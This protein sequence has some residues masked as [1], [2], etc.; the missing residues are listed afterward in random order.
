MSMLKRT[1]VK[2]SVSWHTR[3]SWI[4]GLALFLFAFSGIMHPLMIWT[5]PKP[6]SFFPPQVSLSAEL[7]SRIPVT[8]ENAGI[9]QAVIVRMVPAESGVLLQITEHPEMPRR[10]FDLNNSV[11]L[12]DYDEK[13]AIWLAR[14][15]TGLNNE[16]VAEVSFLNTFSDAYPW[17]NRLLPIYKITFDT[18]DNRTAFI[19]TELGV[20]GNLTNDWKIAIQGVFQFIH[21]W[22]WLDDLEHT[23]V[24]LM[25]CLLLSLLGMSVTGIAMILLLKNREM[26]KKR[27]AHR[28]VAYVIWLPLLMFSTSG[29]YH[30]LQYAYG[31]NHRGLQLSKPIAVTKER[32]GDNMKWL[33][34]YKN[35]ELNGLSIVEGPSG[36][37]LY[38]LSIPQGK[39]G[40][41]LGRQ[42][43]FDGVPI[44]KPALYFNAATGEESDIS[45][46]DMA[47]YYAGEQLAYNESNIVNTQ[48]VTHFGPDYDFRNK[49]LPV[50][51]ID[52][53]AEA[54]DMVFIDPANGMLVDRLIDAESFESY[55]FSFLHKWDFLTPFIG[56]IPRDLLVVL[57]LIIA[58]TGA[59]LGYVMRITK[60]YFR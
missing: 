40:Q 3:L 18:E 54:G 1:L 30:L 45:D 34:Q 22:N 16:P 15:Y 48:L 10:Y 23:R 12:P 29:I 20:L 24:L 59:L 32:F 36:N 6:A 4:G 25:M 35:I 41:S 27:K 28:M 26:Q 49:R 46:R 53:D 55:A 58:I 17:V 14:Y 13:H 52:Y 42:T 2:N 19:Y 39:H 5:G 57:I 44:E 56:R 33:E 37:L 21:T 7:A 60:A 51:R 8:L 9:D 43:R 50:W 47:I 38:R 11:E 31:D